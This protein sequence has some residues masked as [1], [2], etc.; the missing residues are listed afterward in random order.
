MN[1][2]KVFIPEQMRYFNKET[3]TVRNRETQYIVH[4]PLTAE[5]FKLAVSKSNDDWNK[6]CDLLFER[7]G[8]R[9]QGN[10]DLLWLNGR[11]LH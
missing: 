3:L 1:G 11:P 2:T 10:Y 4:F 9:L 5:E 6:M 8:K 7:T